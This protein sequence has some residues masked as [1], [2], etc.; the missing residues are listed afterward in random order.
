MLA[1]VIFAFSASFNQ[2]FKC[3]EGLGL[4]GGVRTTWYPEMSLG[5]LIYE[6]GQ[7]SIG[8]GKFLLPFHARGA[9]WAKRRGTP[10]IRMFSRT[11]A[12][13]VGL[14]NPGHIAPLDPVLPHPAPNRHWGLST[15]WPHLRSAIPGGPGAS[16]PTRKGLAGRFCPS[17]S[18]AIC[19]QGVRT[20]QA[21]PSISR[22]VV[23]PGGGG[24][25]NH[26]LRSAKESLLR[27]SS[28]RRWGPLGRSWGGGVGEQAPSGGSRS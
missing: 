15:A 4:G 8:S 17:P 10:G 26:D 19:R 7:Y 9:G 23:T 3:R 6:M 24:R 16:P 14:P 1:I 18:P 27:S 21:A 5:L 12:P 22:R 28:R 11:P 2:N 25:D 20:H 13:R